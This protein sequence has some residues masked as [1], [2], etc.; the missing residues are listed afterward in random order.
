MSLAKWVN[1]A[2]VPEDVLISFIEM[3]AMKMESEY[4]TLGLRDGS[5]NLAANEKA[6][7]AAKKII[8]PYCPQHSLDALLPELKNLSLLSSRK[9]FTSLILPECQSRARK[10]NFPAPILKKVTS[11]EDGISFL[12]KSLNTLKAP[13]AVQLCA[14]FLFDPSY[15]GVTVRNSVGTPSALDCEG[16]AVMAVGKK[17]I[18]NKCHFLIRNS[19][20]SGW[21]KWAE[22][23]S[24]MCKN[25]STGQLVD[26]CNITTHNNGQFTVEACWVD[27]GPLSRNFYRA[28]TIGK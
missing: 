7:E 25:R 17:Q 13:V 21:G 15:R 23:L 11:D 4:G 27:S 19:W 5:H 16:H 9:L 12:Q 28:F 8:G 6:F 26:D 24:C 20:G 14:N 22:N 10:L 18:A 3:Y 1:E 2:K